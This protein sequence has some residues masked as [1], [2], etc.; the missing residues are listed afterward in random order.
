M[1]D[2]SSMTAEEMATEFLKM[3]MEAFTKAETDKA[4][5]AKEEADKVATA[6]KQDDLRAEIN[7]Y[8]K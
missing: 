2:Y 6:K 8:M 3:K 5:A 7:R 1:S 4:T